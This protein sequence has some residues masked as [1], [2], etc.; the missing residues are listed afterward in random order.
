MQRRGTVIRAYGGFFF[1]LTESGFLTCRPRGRLKL[2]DREI[3]VGDTV[4]VT[5]TGEGTAV[6]ERVLDRKVELHRPRIANVDLAVVVMAA[7][8]P[9]PSTFLID[10]FLTVIA[11][12]GLEAI[13]C[14]NKIDLADRA[15]VESLSEL[16]RLAGYEVLATAAIYGQGVD[17]LALRLSGITSVL[18]GPSGTGKSALLRALCPG[19]DAVVGEISRKTRR[20]RHTTRFVQ[21]VP[22]PSGGLIADSPGFSYLRLGDIRTDE[23]RVLFPGFGELAGTCRFSSCLH[24]DEPGCEIKA[25]VADGRISEIRYENY[26]ELLRETESYQR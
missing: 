18:A 7:R 25:A 23:L 19:V 8:D 9:D 5:I 15:E 14:S 10:R 16:Y 26:L 21:L 12:A 20:G 13:L 22:L 4:D 3:I 1:V 11:H 17:E 24:R 2:A 6:I